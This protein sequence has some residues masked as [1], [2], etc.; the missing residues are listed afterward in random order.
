VLL[1]TPL[2]LRAVLTGWEQLLPELPR[3]QRVACE[4]LEA[5]PISQ[6]LGAT[7][8]VTNCATEQGWPGGASENAF[9]D[10]LA[11]AG[12]LSGLTLRAARPT[13]AGAAA[14]CRRRGGRASDDGGMLGP[15]RASLVA[16]AAGGG[17]A[18][19]GVARHSAQLALASRSLDQLP[20][21]VAF[22]ADVDPTAATAAPLAAAVPASQ[23]TR[24]AI[25]TAASQLSHAQLH[26]VME[27][28]DTSALHGLC[29][30]AV[31][32]SATRQLP[33]TLVL[34]PLQLLGHLASLQ[35]QFTAPACTASVATLQDGT[36]GEG[37]AGV[38]AAGMPAPLHDQQQHRWRRDM[39]CH[40]TELLQLAVSRLASSMW[41][42]YLEAGT[43]PHTTVLMG[44]GRGCTAQYAPLWGLPAVV[45]GA[46]AVSLPAC[47]GTAFARAVVADAEAVVR[48][49][50]A[51]GDPLELPSLL[52]R[53]EQ[54][55]AGVRLARRD[56][57]GLPTWR[58]I[59]RH[60]TRF[61]AAAP[62]A[63]GGSGVCHSVSLN[64]RH[65]A[66]GGSAVANLTSVE[67]GVAGA[68]TIEYRAMTQQLDIQ[69]QR[70]AGEFKVAAD[71]GGGGYLSGGGTHAAP[72]DRVLAAVVGS[73]CMASIRAMH[74]DPSTLRLHSPASYDAL[75]QP[76]G[77]ARVAFVFVWGVDGSVG[78]GVGRETFATPACRYSAC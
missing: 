65:P 3:L 15:L 40:L 9:G 28:V 13:P 62:G 52:S 36:A 49:F 27:A 19:V 55:A 68:T 54:C 7:A 58:D 43:L 67:Q 11:A 71:G 20:R 38:M 35:A 73:R 24:A 74:L 44:S 70:L 60:V 33:A 4:C 50:E 56:V 8:S 42:S 25:D 23:E 63:S 41:G 22:A 53:V 47:L 26:C 31:E 32:L 69:L 76:A 77:M 2:H 72:R 16:R 29:G 45:V 51:V 66:A 6:F 59:W 17:G 46:C 14:R 12:D 10:L 1:T 18:V 5:G 37:V 21:R 64:H 61:P 75:H 30:A 39:Q 78:G 34:V 48:R 57:P